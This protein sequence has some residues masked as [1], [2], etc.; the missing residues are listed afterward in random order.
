MIN[1]EILD[2][3][4]LAGALRRVARLIDLAPA[5]RAEL[6]PAQHLAL[7]MDHLRALA[8]GHDDADHLALA[9]VSL[10]LALRDRD[11]DLRAQAADAAFDDLARS[12]GGP[13][14]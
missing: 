2:R 13:R 12:F 4:G 1:I 14:R 8:A 6:E 10:L 7:A 9:A 3:S 5:L 11:G